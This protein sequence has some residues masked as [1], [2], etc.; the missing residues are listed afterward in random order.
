MNIH[1]D[2]CLLVYV[3]NFSWYLVDIGR[4]FLDIG[5]FCWIIGAY[6]PNIWA[7]IVHF[8]IYF[9]AEG[10]VRGPFGPEP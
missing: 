4:Y 1:E 2:Q 7:R 6:F 9:E 5:P 10:R 8:G 3:V